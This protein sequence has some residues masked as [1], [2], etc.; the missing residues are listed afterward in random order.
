MGEPDTVLYGI[1]TKEGR[2]LLFEYNIYFKSLKSFYV[3]GKSKSIFIY[4]CDTCLPE[5]RKFRMENDL[6][7]K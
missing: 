4:H 2:R 5:E 3:K 1:I 7:E 6:L